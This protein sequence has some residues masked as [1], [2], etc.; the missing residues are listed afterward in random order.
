MGTA[1]GGRLHKFDQEY[2]CGTLQPGGAANPTRGNVLLLTIQ[3][4]MISIVFF[5]AMASFES[6]LESE[7]VGGVFETLLV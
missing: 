2:R 3:R 7:R 5:Y 1:R 6:M 4:L